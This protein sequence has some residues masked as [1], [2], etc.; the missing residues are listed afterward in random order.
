MTKETLP[1]VFTSSS[2]HPSTPTSPGEKEMAKFTIDVYSDTLCPF[3][4]IGKRSL[5]RAIATYRASHPEAQFELVWHPFLIHPKFRGRVAGNKRD[6]FKAKYGEDRVEAFFARL[7]ERGAPLGIRFVWDGRSGSSWD[8]HK[9]MLRALD[10]DREGG[11]EEG[12]RQEA[13]LE[14]LFGGVFEEGRDVSDLGFLARCA[15]EAGVAGSEEEARG[16]MGSEEMGRRVEWESAQGRKREI[17]AVPSYLVQ[18]RYFVGG[19]QEPEVFEDVFRRVGEWERGT[20]VAQGGRALP[21]G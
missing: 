9:L 11:G 3:C 13:L 4:Y 6:Y 1:L 12:G 2:T 10:L 15:V 8:S 21:L 18:G 5:D 16:V 17:E 20:A 19:M 14:R 7:E